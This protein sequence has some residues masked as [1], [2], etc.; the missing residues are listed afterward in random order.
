MDSHQHH[1]CIL[2]MSADILQKRAKDASVADFIAFHGM[3]CLP[4]TARRCVSSFDG[5]ILFADVQDYLSDSQ[6]RLVAKDFSRRCKGR[7]FG[8]NSF[9]YYLLVLCSCTG[10]SSLLGWT[11]LFVHKSYEK[12]PTINSS[13]SSTI[14]IPSTTHPQLVVTPVCLQYILLQCSKAKVDVGGGET[15]LVLR[16]RFEFEFGNILQV[17]MLHFICSNGQRHLVE[18]YQWKS[19]AIEAVVSR[20]FGIVHTLETLLL[21][22]LSADKT[23]KRKT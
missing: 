22:F 21:S 7:F 17:M 5:V 14:S 6:E 1:P 11:K 16:E 15:S 19:P 4:S 10:F 20:V 3:F 8:L 2:K 18:V 12:H 9:T 13:N 23:N